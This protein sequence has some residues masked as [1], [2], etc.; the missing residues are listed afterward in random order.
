MESPI[1]YFSNLCDPRIDRTKDH[2]LE[3]IIFVDIDFFLF[4]LSKIYA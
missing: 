4:R 2:L 3:D 1:S